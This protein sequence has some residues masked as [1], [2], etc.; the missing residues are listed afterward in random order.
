MFFLTFYRLNNI[1]NNQREIKR[2]IKT[3]NNPLSQK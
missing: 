1:L 2:L 3:E